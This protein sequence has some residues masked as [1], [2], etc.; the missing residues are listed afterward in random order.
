MRLIDQQTINGFSVFISV[1]GALFIFLRASN[2]ESYFTE[3]SETIL[4]SG[5]IVF[6]IVGL[7]LLYELFFTSMRPN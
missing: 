7:L 1:I 4:V 3:S 6:T 2:L 5:I